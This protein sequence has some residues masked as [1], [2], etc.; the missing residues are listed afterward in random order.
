MELADSN[1]VSALLNAKRIVEMKQPSGRAALCRARHDG[2][3]FDEREM[4]IPDVNTRM[5]KWSHLA[6]VR[7]EGGDICSF[8]A[9]ALEAGIRKVAEFGGATMLFREDVIR[10]MTIRAK[11][12]IIGLL[13]IFTASLSTF[14]H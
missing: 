14:Y 10:L 2:P 6:G 4:F 12:A 5:E 9:V 11:L 7:I 8:M 1:Q 3:I 13:A